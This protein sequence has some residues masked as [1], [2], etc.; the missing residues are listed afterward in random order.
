M[1][2]ATQ[3][4]KSGPRKPAAGDDPVTAYAKS[5]ANGTILAG[6]LVRLECQR[7]LDNLQRQRTKEFPYYFD[8]AA[9][10]RVIDFF[11]DFLTLELGDPFVLPPWLQFCYGALFG[12][13]CWGGERVEKQK[14]AFDKWRVEVRLLPDHQQPSRQELARRD[15]AWREGDLWIALAGHS[16]HGYRKHQHGY[17]ETSKG[18]GKSPSAGG[19]ALYLAGFDGEAYAQIYSTGFDKGQAA[20]ILKDAI[21][22]VENAPDD[23]FRAEF[24]VG[25]HSIL[26]IPSGSIIQAMS[27]QHQSKSGPRPSAV[28]S[29][30]I[31]EQR[32]GTVVSKAE[33]GF[34]NRKQPL[35]LKYTNS[36]SDRAS[37]CWQLH[38]KSIDVLEGRVVDE[39]WFSYV[40]HLDP[41]QECFNQGYRQPKDGCEDCD[42]WMSPAVWPKVAPALGV[43]IQ[44]KYLQDAIDTALSVPSDYN[45]KRRLNFCIWTE[46]HNVWIS[47]DQWDSCKAPSVLSSN[48]DRRP[49]AAAF[50]L[51][52]KY[53]LSSLV[54]AIRFDDPPGAKAEEV[55]IEGM[56]ESGDRIVQTL[57]LNFSIELIPFFWIPKDTLLERVRTERI[58]YDV[59]HK[60]E[61]LF[62]TD[63]AVIDHHEIYEFIVGNKAK[64]SKGAMHTFGIQK[65][66]YDDHDATMFATQLRDQGRLGDKVVAVPQGKKLSEV[67]KLIELLV[68]SRRLRHDGHDVLAWNIAN[69]EPHRDRLGALWIEKASETKR[70]DGVTATEMAIHQLMVLPA[71]KRSSGLFVA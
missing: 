42:N 15:A 25:K 51:S 61:K 64:G 3:P 65:L 5:V 60:Q 29:D 33:A 43:V 46:T 35:G 36:G 37:Y 34:K 68:R 6:R 45:L 9:A 31:H 18:S 32:N 50:D 13:K 56:D 28:L 47:S 8:Q 19:I 57:T 62:V 39:Q 26:H 58:P 22:M 4:R 20:I 49:C 63:G 27:S 54:V 11:P 69:V 48:P 2:T 71:R 55:K 67:N 41:C 40:C 21:R 66:G 17:F 24:E 70:I 59:W 30:E 7:H 16:R 14:A 52:S 10:Q 23:E 1:A 53:D 12:W 44:P 38:Q